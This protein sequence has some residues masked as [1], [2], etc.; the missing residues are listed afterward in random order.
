MQKILGL[1]RRA[2]QDYNMIEAGDRIAVGVSGGK[3]SVTLLCGLA[4][5]RDFYPIP[6]EL[7]AITVDPC[8]FSKECDLSAVESLCGRLG[9]PY[10]VRRS[11]IGRVVFDIRNEKNPCSLCAKLRKGAL[12]RE[13]AARGCNKVALGHHMDDAVETFMMNLIR[14]GRLGCYS[15]VTYLS[16][17]GI[18]LIRPLLYASEK[19]IG[20]N[21]R[22]N[23]LPVLE[24]PCPTNGHTERARMKELLRELNHEFPDIKNMLFGALKRSH[25]DGW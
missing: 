20:S 6:F 15:P 18:T 1:M 14:G 5:L 13:A 11:N 16:R 7:A 4:K 22:K 12:H 24:N 2:I 21:V 25:I 23:G 10:S 8:F 19:E 3:D 9:V 17:S